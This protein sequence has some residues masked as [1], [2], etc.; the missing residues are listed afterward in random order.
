MSATARIFL[1]CTVQIDLNYDSYIDFTKAGTG[2]TLTGNNTNDEASLKIEATHA[3]FKTFTIGTDIYGS[4]WASSVGS[5]VAASAEDTLFLIPSGSVILERITTSE[6]GF[7]W[8]LAPTVTTAHTWSNTQT[9]ILS[10]LIHILLGGLYSIPY[11]FCL[12]EP[13]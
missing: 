4:D 13:A 9:F 10:L 6:T 2:I 3:A 7:K 5:E 1:M 11:S 8:S 12:N